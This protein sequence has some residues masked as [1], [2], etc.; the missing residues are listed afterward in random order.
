[1]GKKRKEREVSSVWR[2]KD[3]KW[4]RETDLVGGEAM[5]HGRGSVS[6]Q[7]YEREDENGKERGRRHR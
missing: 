6:M 1:M 5:K 3:E 2:G 4:G 7:V